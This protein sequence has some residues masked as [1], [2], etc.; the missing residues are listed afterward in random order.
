[1]AALDVEHFLFGLISTLLIVF[2][3]LINSLWFFFFFV[4]I[5]LLFFLPG[6]FLAPK[7]VLPWGAG[8]GSPRPGYVLKNEKPLYTSIDALV[9]VRPLQQLHFRSHQTNHIKYL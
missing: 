6:D 5:I 8:C 4:L 2:F 3:G 7:T 1:M 9:L